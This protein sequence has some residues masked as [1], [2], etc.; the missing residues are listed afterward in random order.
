MAAMKTK[1]VRSVATAAVLALSLLC[2]ASAQAF[3]GTAGS[4]E[5]PTTKGTSNTWW[6]NYTPE[7]LGYQM[8]FTVY[9]DGVEVASYPKNY[10]TGGHPPEGPMCTREFS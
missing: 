2:A 8:C 5:P 4:G 7:P 9:K 3:V 10:P 1:T 6:F